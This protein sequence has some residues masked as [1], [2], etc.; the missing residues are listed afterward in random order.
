MLA[1]CHQQELVQVSITRSADAGETPLLDTIVSIFVENT[2]T[3]DDKSKEHGDDTAQTFE[4][5][6]AAY[7]AILMCCLSVDNASNARAIR[8]ALPGETFDQVLAH[9]ED[10]IYFQQ[11]AGVEQSDTGTVQRLMEVLAAENV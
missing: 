6:V 7:V 9:L 8:E 3:L 11:A 10:Y 5:I 1:I 2:A 4:N